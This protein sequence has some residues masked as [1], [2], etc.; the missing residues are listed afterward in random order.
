MVRQRAG[1]RQLGLFSRHSA[2]RL[3]FSHVT[4]GLN[5]RNYLFFCFVFI[6]LLSEESPVDN[7]DSRE[8]SPE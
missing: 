6:Y 1:P 2:T 7:P 5:S 8:D 3:D 4:V